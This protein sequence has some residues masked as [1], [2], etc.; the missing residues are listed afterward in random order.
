MTNQR[1]RNRRDS[2]R[3]AGEVI[4][5]SEYDVSEITG[6]SAAKAFVLEHHYSASYPAARWRFGLYKRGELAGVAVFSQPMHNAVLRDFP[7]RSKSSVELGRFVLLDEVPGNGETWFLARCFEQLRREGVVG[8]VSFSDDQPRDTSEGCVV[9]GGHMGTIYQAF[10]G[11]YCGRAR[12]QKLML[13]PDGNVF[14]HRAETKIRNREQGWVY[15]SRQLVR[16]GAAPL[17]ENE[18]AKAWMES[19]KRALIREVKHPGN[20]KYI[21]AVDKRVR[22]H[23]E[24]RVADGLLKPQPYPKRLA[25]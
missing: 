19:W 18:N 4:R 12:G 13:L 3:P 5:T 23:L 16:Y 21:W 20:H 25:S 15:A 7:G 10:N 22:K 24:K 2:Y 11:M 6:D 1:W 14:S 9:F 17:G 8:V